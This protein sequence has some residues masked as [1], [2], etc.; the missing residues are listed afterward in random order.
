MVGDGVFDNSTLNAT[1]MALV[2]PAN[3]Q[4]SQSDVWFPAKIGRR[5]TDYYF[6]QPFHIY[7]LMHLRCEG[8]PNGG[9]DTSTRLMFPAG[10]HG[11]VFDNYGTSP[12]GTGMGGGGMTS[13]GVYSKG[14]HVRFPVVTG[15]NPTIQVGVDKWGGTWDFHVG[16]GVVIFLF[17]PTDSAPV[18]PGGTTVAA[19]N[20]GAQTITPSSPV[21]ST[22]TG[23]GSTVWR[24][25]VE[26]AFTVNTV[27]G[28]GTITVTGGPSLLQPGDY[29]WSDAFPFG[30]PVIERQPERLA[31]KPPTMA[32]WHMGLTMQTQQTQR[33]PIQTGTPEASMWIT[34]RCDQE[35][36]YRPA[37]VTNFLTGFGPGL[38][39]CNAPA[40][41]PPMLRK[42]CN[43]S[44]AQEN[45]F[46]GNMIGR[47]VLGDNSGASASIM[48]VYSQDTVADIAEG[49][50]VGSRIL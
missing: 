3:T 11:V 10:V 4:G 6:S 46:F 44:L 50:A 29:I 8:I 35:R 38:E 22:Y 36:T 21:V 32:P 45:I 13:C 2:N 23:D 19:V 48:N 37:C 20:P 14:Y 18:L 43:D 47:L 24:L 42:G 34:S 17:G 15:S 40:W 39:E 26:K 33:R 12:D 31:R 16:D 9:G 28:S 41:G 30:T 7:R 27:S 25:P 1:L 49:G 5:Y